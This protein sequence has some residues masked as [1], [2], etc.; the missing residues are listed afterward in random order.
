MLWRLRAPLALVLG[1][2]VGGILTPQP[3]VADEFNQQTGRERIVSVGQ[4]AR[5]MRG[6]A[7]RADYV[8]LDGMGEIITYVRPSADL[9]LD[10][11]LG[12]EVGVTAI[13]LT[14]GEI[15]L[16]L[17]EHVT[18]FG[19]AD[20]IASEDLPDRPTDFV[21]AGRLRTRG[22][23]RGT[24]TLPSR[25]GVSRRA[26]VAPAAYETEE[27]PYGESIIASDP[28]LSG[29]PIDS[30][31]EAGIEA[32][33]YMPSYA[34]ENVGN[35]P[36]CGQRNGNCS[37]CVPCPCG[38]VGR[39]WLRAEYLL[40]WTKGADSPALVTTGPPGTIRDLAGV[41]GANGTET[42]FGGRILDGSRSGARFRLGKWC[43]Q[44]QWIGFETDFFFLSDQNDGFHGCDIGTGIV[45]RP[46]FNVAEN[47]QDSELIQFP[48]VVVGS[49]DVNAESTLYSIGPRFRINL[50]CLGAGGSCSTCSSM[51]GQR[52]DMLLGYRY[53]R[54]DDQITIR[55]QLSTLGTAQTQTLFDVRDS[56]DA[57]NDFHGGDLGLL[58]ERYRGPWSLELLGRVALGNNRETVRI[59]GTTR[60]TTNSQSFVDEGGILALSSNNGS[61]SR[62]QFAVIPEFGATL[63]YALTSNLR[64]TAGYTFLYWNNVVRAAEQID[65]NVNPNLF[66]PPLAN[67]GPASPAFAFNEAS[68]WAQ[69]LSLGLD[70]RW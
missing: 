67:P 19:D 1:L 33:A 12:Q 28:I 10:G 57:T 26:V 35:C 50:A 5:A 3:S 37:S 27:L 49:I 36:S 29:E 24:F 13:Q 68:Y 7:T 6:R 23:Q 8:L 66:P 4:L 52:L 32:N 55:E 40:W 51:V 43:D 21:A 69:G 39:Y 11:F 31:I 46:F 14:D 15:P 56:F 2:C 58:W 38:P 20:P 17:A 59:N 22:P 65:T 25:L 16:L 9:N 48:G 70:Y 34:Y 53:M 45:A 54:L 63:G 47:R 44:C 62:N 30:G 18:T 64:I 42:L 60:T 41:L 61:Y